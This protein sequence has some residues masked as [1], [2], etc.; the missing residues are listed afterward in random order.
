ME[1]SMISKADELLRKIKQLEQELITEI[2]KQQQDFIS[3]ANHNKA[4]HQDINQLQ[5]FSNYLKN[6]SL[7]NIIS[8]PF[9]WSVIFPVLILDVAVSLYQTLC[10]PLYGIPQVRHADYIVFDRKYLPY[11]NFME[12]INCGYCSYF[13]GA[14]AYIQEVAARTEQYWCPIKHA[15]RI[16][17]I[18]SRYQYFIDYGDAASFRQHKERVRRNFEDLT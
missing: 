1:T 15:K 8:T 18:H 13:N 3:T 7:K 10:F 9:I 11:L 14:I 2:Q 6:A 16:S 12:K 17:T 5:A 4:A